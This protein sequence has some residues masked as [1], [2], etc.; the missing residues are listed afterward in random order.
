MIAS[1]AL[2]GAATV[3][4]IATNAHAE[5]S[6]VHKPVMTVVGQDELAGDDT[7]APAPDG[8]SPDMM[9]DDGHRRAEFC[10]AMYAHKVGELAFMEAQLS[11]TPAQQPLFEHW[12][13]A[14]LD[15][16]KQHE[17]DCSN[18]EPH[19]RGERP[20]VVD[21]LNREETMLRQR[22]ADIDAEKPALTA[23]YAS[24]SDQQKQEF[25][26]D[27]M[28]HRGGPDDG[29]DGPSASRHGR[30]DGPW[31]HGWSARPDGPGRCAAPAAGA[32]VFKGRSG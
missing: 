24:L 20:S 1:L 5:Q 18:H 19:Q 28:H 32:V 16:A 3:A 23:F 6:T 10:K 2:C 11:L 4:L 15:I 30:P 7:A 29:H 27:G 13:Q 26:H 8:G 31:P 25:G 9:R 22:L 17:G 14:S 12:K 21:R